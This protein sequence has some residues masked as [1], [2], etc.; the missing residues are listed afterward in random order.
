MGF[1]EVKSK[2][3]NLSDFARKLSKE[4]GIVCN[5]S[6]FQ[7]DDKASWVKNSLKPIYESLS[8]ACYQGNKT[9]KI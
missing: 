8:L 5:I 3:K 4:E 7:Y 6:V 1:I 9:P 2:S